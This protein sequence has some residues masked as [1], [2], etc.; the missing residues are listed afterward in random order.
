MKKNQTIGI[1]LAALLAFIFLINS[2]SKTTEPGTTAGATKKEIKKEGDKNKP[3]Q[4]ISE[5]PGAS[6]SST[7]DTCGSCG[8]YFSA[9]HS[10]TGFYAY[11]D[12]P[13]NLSCAIASSTITVGCV[14][15]DVPNRYTIYDVNGSVVA[16]TGWIGWAHCSGPWG[17]SVTTPNYETFMNFTYNSSLAPYILRVETNVIGCSGGGCSSDPGC[18]HGDDNWQVHISCVTGCCIPTEQCGSCGTY[19]NNNHAGTGYYLYPDN[20]LDLSCAKDT[21]TVTIGCTY[22]DVP[23]RFTVY[24][25]NGV[26]VTT[27]W[28]GWAHCTGPWGF[29]VTTPQA[30]TFISFT[31]YSSQAPYKLRVETTVIACSGSCSSDAG[32]RDADDNWLAHVM[33]VL[34]QP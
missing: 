25:K 23:N 4:V 8:K 5:Q 33:C 2:C 12:I 27:N 21:S 24:D 22:Y 26:V 16:T 3:L 28:I 13:L 14:Y 9:T 17:A 7:N 19:L 34:K 30:E 15:Y 11:P 10:G 18:T 31:Y 20:T 6:L 32:C 1:S 29:S